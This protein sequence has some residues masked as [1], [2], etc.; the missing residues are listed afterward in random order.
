MSKDVSF[1]ELIGANGALR[2]AC[3]RA[4]IAADSG[5][6]VFLWGEPGV[7]KETLARAIAGAC[8]PYR[9]F[10]PLDGRT[11]PWRSW[12]R[13]ISST[14]E[15]VVVFI[16]G[17]ER[18]PRQVGR[19]LASAILSGK[20]KFQTVFSSTKPCQTLTSASNFSSELATLFG[21]F[22]IFLP[23]L[24]ERTHD[25]DALAVC[26]FADATAEARVLRDPLTPDELTRL[27]AFDYPDNLDGLRRVLKAVAERD[28]FPRT[29]AE[30][31]AL[32]S[33]ESPEQTE[34]TVSSSS[35]VLAARSTSNGEPDGDSSEFLTLDQAMK[36]HIERALTRSHG[37]VEG[38]NG[39][40]KALAINPYTLR[41]RM[42][43]L[44]ID[45][46][47]F[48]KDDASDDAR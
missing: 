31:E 21:A 10:L 20:V 8:R 46:T 40:A 39:A 33:P 48:R 14:D 44:G 12:E 11:V 5:V 4:K 2:G 41:A 3:D 9:K 17:A 26:F 32:V 42:V 15:D 45:W 1:D 43:K 34:Q 29:A 38:K 16:D 23:P 24:R 47:A 6:S 37:V 35:P 7:G 25:F 13:L 28:V 22:P 30:L 19:N 27:R 18:I 36:A